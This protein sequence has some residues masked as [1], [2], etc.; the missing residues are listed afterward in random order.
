MQNFVPAHP[1]F[2]FDADWYHPDGGVSVNRRIFDVE[3]YRPILTVTM[4]QILLD[5]FVAE[6]TPEQIAYYNKSGYVPRLRSID[7]I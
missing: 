5:I 2:T 4:F 1:A 6:F 3:G 7:F